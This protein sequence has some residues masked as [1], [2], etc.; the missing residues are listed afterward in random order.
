MNPTKALVA[1]ACAVATSASFAVAAPSP[2]SEGFDDVSTL[3]GKG[4][5][6][7]N[8][9]TPPGTTGWFQGDTG[10]FS[11]AAGAANSYVAANFNNAGYGGAISNWLITPQLV[12]GTGMTLDF[13]VRAAGQDFADTL[14]VRWSANGAST[15]VGGDAASVGDF[16]QLLYTYDSQGADAGWLAKSVALPSGSGRI[17]FRYTIGDTS[18][19]GNYVGIDTVSVVP[20]PASAAFLVVGLGAIGLAARRRRAA[21]R[22][23][24][25]LGQEAKEPR[26]ATAA[27]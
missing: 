17:A 18:V 22:P 13:M 3:S 8:N 23:R 9:S 7:V 25:A 20:E 1:A 27:L 2:L 14:E 4:W 11:A 6:L 15:N 21:Q 12:L 19:A 5:A 16:T 24:Q 26:E 10:V